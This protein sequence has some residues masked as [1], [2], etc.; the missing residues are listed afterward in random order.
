MNLD[1]VWDPVNARGDRQ[2]TAAGRTSTGNLLRTAVIISLFTDRRAQPDWVPPD[3]NS[4]DPR[5]WYWDT[6]G[7]PIGSRLWQL[8]RRKIAN[9]NALLLE[10]RDMIQEALQWMQDQQIVSAIAINVQSAGTL[11]AFNVQLSQPTG[12]LPLIRL[13]WNPVG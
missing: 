2:I 5:G 8:R 6:F 12:P 4:D 10:A 9:R 7:I 1:I 13:L 3:R 11:L